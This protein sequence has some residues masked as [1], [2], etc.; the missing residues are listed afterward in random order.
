MNRKKTTKTH[1]TVKEFK[2][3]KANGMETK[4]KSLMIGEDAHK[5]IMGMADN[6][7]VSQPELVE[8]LLKTADKAKLAAALSEI[9]RER[10]LQAAERDRKEKA[11][12]EAA[13]KMRGMSV[14]D[15]EA[16]LKK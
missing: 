6:F 14:A 12:A 10:E 7:G 3:R 15:I 2:P 11:I 9:A 13:K 1:A 8:A 16:L 4:R 5:H